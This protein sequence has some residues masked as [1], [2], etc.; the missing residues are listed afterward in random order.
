[1][2][3]SGVREHMHT[4]KPIE[5]MHHDVTTRTNFFILKTTEAY[6]FYQSLTSRSAVIVKSSRNKSTVH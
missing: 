5:M 1:M 2:T 4:C 3:F 6:Q